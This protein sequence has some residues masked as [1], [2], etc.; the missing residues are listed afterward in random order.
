MVVFN[1]SEG[2]KP[3]AFLNR[4]KNFAESYYSRSEIYQSNPTVVLELSHIKFELT[5]AYIDYGKLYYIPKD[6]SNWMYT[7]PD[8]FYDE[9]TNCNK[10]NNYRIKPIIRIIKHWN[11]QKNYRDVKS[12]QLEKKIAEEMRYEYFSCSSYTDYL[13][14]ALNKIKY[15]TDTNRINKTI[16]C[17]N[18]ALNYEKNNMPYSAL[19]R[20]KDFFPEV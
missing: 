14:S 6:Q 3:Q 17:I 20:I 18:D 7:D 4:L 1:N 12:Y 8:G 13:L 19:S 16:E 10:M 9:L 5:P 15:M 11:I 2:Y